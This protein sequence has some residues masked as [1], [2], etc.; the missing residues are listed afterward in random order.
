MRKLWN[1]N[2]KSLWR[3]LLTHFWIIFWNRLWITFFGSF[4]GQFLAAC[5]QTF[6]I[7]SRSNFFDPVYFFF[8]LTTF[9]LTFLPHFLLTLRV[10]LW[11]FFWTTFRLR[12]ALCARSFFNV[13]ASVSIH[14]L[15]AFFDHF[16]DCYFW[17]RHLYRNGDPIVY[18][19]SAWPLC[20]L[21]DLG[22]RTYTVN[23]LPDE[24][25]YWYN[26][27]CDLTRLDRRCSSLT[28]SDSMRTWDAPTRC[29]EKVYTNIANLFTERDFFFSDTIL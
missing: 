14:Y 7:T 16:L 27:Q 29:R 13:L 12:I 8:L 6:S 22:R 20:M 23:F 1:L 2:G 10:T 5:Q 11:S 15:N 3:Q 19:S 9:S 17:S 28:R 24:C 25:C 18:P 26:G 4:W 21:T